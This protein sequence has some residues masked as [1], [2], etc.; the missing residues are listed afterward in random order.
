MAAISPH[1]DL[2]SYSASKAGLAAYGTALRRATRGSGVRI[3]VVLPGFVDTPM[4]DRQRGPTPF[5]IS[6]DAAARRI[7]RGLDRRRPVIAFPWPLAALL[8]L[9][10][11]LPTAAADLIDARFRAEILPDRDEV[12]Q[13]GDLAK[14]SLPTGTGAGPGS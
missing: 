4:T 12:E 10:S 8:F 3:S 14:R 13:E 5:R 2:L 11:L 7:R 1:A 9:Q 6:A